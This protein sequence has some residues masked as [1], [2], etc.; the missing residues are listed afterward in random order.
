MKL[1]IIIL[2]SSKFCGELPLQL[3]ELPSLQVLDQ[4][5]NDFSGQIPPSFGDFNAMMQD[6][7]TN[8][9]LFYGFYRG[10]S[11]EESLTIITKGGQQEHTKT[12]SL[13]TSIDL[14][15]NNIDGELPDELTKL[16]G[17]LVLNLS[18]NHTS[19]QIPKSI[20]NMHQLSSL[21]L[22]SNRLSGAIPTSMSSSL[23]FLSYLNLS[24]NNF[25]G[26]VPY[27]E[28]MSTFDASSSVGNPGLCG[29]PLE[30]ECLRDEGS[31]GGEGG[32][33]SGEEDDV[34]FIDGWFY[35]SLGVGFA[36]GLSIPCIMLL[37]RKPWSDAYL[38]QLQR[39]N[40]RWLALLCKWEIEA[41][42]KSRSK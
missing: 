38:L 23:T 27:S 2:R 33:N 10:I 11:Y 13:V 7:I 32:A 12:L 18:R 28:Q 24:Y 16:T 36:A 19:G 4:A 34:G 29:P 41:E 37:V 40:S 15:G 20:S 22:S 31:G 3:S 26:K 17:L 39:W 30:V 8:Q 42:R 35:L 5:E 9:Y 25:S 21:D 14:S 1:R 6:Q